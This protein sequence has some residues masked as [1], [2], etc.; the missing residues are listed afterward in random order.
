MNELIACGGVALSVITLIP[1]L[2]GLFGEVPQA[3]L[4]A[5]TYDLTGCV[6]DFAKFFIIIW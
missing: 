4:P 5:C 1:L 2:S 3:G 6:A